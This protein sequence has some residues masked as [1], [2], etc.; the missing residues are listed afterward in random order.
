MLNSMLWPAFIT[1]LVFG[2]FLY[3]IMKSGN[4]DEKFRKEGIK[5]EAKIIS[6]QHIS[7]SGTGNMKL[8]FEFMIPD[9]VV[10]TYA[11]RFITPEEMVKIGRKNTVCLY[12]LPGAPE[13]VYLVPGDME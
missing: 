3:S 6:K 4:N 9:G 7:T 5:V 11:R 13:K 10:V 2:W 8:E 1:I 12:Y